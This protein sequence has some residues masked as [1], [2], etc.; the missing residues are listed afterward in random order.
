MSLKTHKN[1]EKN[2][3]IQKILKRLS[4]LEALNETLSQQLTVEISQRQ[5]LEKLSFSTN[6]NF[7]TQLNILQKTFDNF[8]DTLNKNMEKLK[9][10]I[11]DDYNKKNKEFLDYIEKTFKSPLTNTSK[12]NLDINSDKFFRIQQMI[13]NEFNQ[14]KS[15]LNSN[16]LNT[17][18]HSKKL[19][20]VVINFS[21]DLN[22]IQKEIQ[23]LKNENE[24][25][26]NFRIQTISE[27][28]KINDNNIEKDNSSENYNKRIDNI[29]LDMNSKMKNY[30]D[31]FRNHNNNF[32]ILKNDFHSQI[33][34]M[35]NFIKKNYKD[36]SNDFQT[37]INNFNQEMEYFEK[38]I[39]NEQDKFIKYVQSNFDE[40]NSSLK[41][42]FDYAND[43]IEILK[44]RS[45]DIEDSINK[46]RTD[47]FKNIN[48]TEEFF[49]KKYDSLFR[50]INKVN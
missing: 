17:E 44:E 12:N 38:H 40:Q 35:N 45:N 2:M 26:K 33:K 39:I 48:E 19:N 16:V 27:I 9:N 25:L 11:S 43:D 30:D 47:V 8:E 49:E 4:Q 37:K 29:L 32:E 20:D 36:V 13:E 3:E 5:N 31:I 21:N 42:L 14:Y 34:E 23:S 46:L 15:E 6:E 28:N 7:S 10:D 24:Q 22:G 50:I 18:Y 1:I 41:K